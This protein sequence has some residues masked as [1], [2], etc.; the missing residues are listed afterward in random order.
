MIDQNI[1]TKTMHIQRRLQTRTRHKTAQTIRLNLQSES[2][3]SKP[4][5]AAL[6]TID[7]DS[8]RRNQAKLAAAPCSSCKLQPPNVFIAVLLPSQT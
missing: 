4:S 8:L 1:P 3:K 5:L 6:P 7:I 2:R